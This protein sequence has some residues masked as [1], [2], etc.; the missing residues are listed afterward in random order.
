MKCEIWK[1]IVS[2][3]EVVFLSPEGLL[4]GSLSLSLPL[5]FYFFILLQLQD[6]HLLQ[7]VGGGT[8]R[9]MLASCLRGAVLL[10]GFSC[11]KPGTQLSHQ[12][13][14]ASLYEQLVWEWQLGLPLYLWAIKALEELACK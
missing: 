6:V 1:E 9:P 3:G 10:R 12:A 7:S 2:I 8:R 14:G 4:P 11:Q 5:L 13:H